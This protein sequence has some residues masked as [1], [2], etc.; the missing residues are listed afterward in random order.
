MFK[1]KKKQTIEFEGEKYKEGDTL[2]ESFNPYAKDFAACVV[3]VEEPKKQRKAPA[4]K[5]KQ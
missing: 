1:L 3:E 5:E 4:S 2:P